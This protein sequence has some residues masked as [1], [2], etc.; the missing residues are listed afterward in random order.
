VALQEV[1][2]VARKLGDT[3]KNSA[4][5]ALQEEQV[6]IL[7]E[8]VE[9]DETLLH[10]QNKI[11]SL[12]TKAEKDL[13]KLKEEGISKATQKEAHHQGYMIRRG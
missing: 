5:V 4:A 6:K 12:L 9:I 3:Q 7:K 13:K 10:N 8:V 1:V 2:E 11:R